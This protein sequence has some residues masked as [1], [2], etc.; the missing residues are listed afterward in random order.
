MK[1]LEKDRNRRYET[2]NGFALDIQRYLADEPVSA[3]PPS[4]SYRFRKFLRRNK[5]AVSVAVT[6]AGSAVAALILTIALLATHSVAIQE[7]QTKTDKEYQRA[8][9]ALREA[10]RN[11]NRADQNLNLALEA[12]DD[13]CL[14]DMEN[15]IFR[16]RQISAAERESLQRGL[17]FTA[18][19]PSRIAVT[20]RCKA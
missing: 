17:A 1:A 11:L 10:N 9:S 20:Q 7:E 15:R 16:E 18:A 4:A 2:A 8:E 14:K 6:A 5:R 12:L 19:S 3:C 13:L